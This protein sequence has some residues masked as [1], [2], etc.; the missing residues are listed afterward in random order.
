[1]HN[2]PAGCGASGAYA[3]GPDKRRR[4]PMQELIPNFFSCNKILVTTMNEDSKLRYI[5]Y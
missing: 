4:S 5:Y 2:G 3:L 1:M